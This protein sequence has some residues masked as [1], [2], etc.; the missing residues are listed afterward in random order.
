MPNLNKVMLM[1]NLTRDPELRYLPSNTPV[2]NFGVA[3][4]RRWTD[5]QSNEKREETTFVDVSAFGR[6]AEVINQY[7]KKGRPIF[8]EGRL[9]FE[10]W[11]DQS[12]NNRNRLTV[13]CEQFE[14]VGGRGEDD[15]GGGGGG[16]YGGGGGNYGNSGEGG[17]G[18]GGGG[19]QQNQAPPPPVD[20]PP[21]MPEEDIPF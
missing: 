14:F 1:G 10:Q 4:N 19:R 16:N 6:T 7:F 21:P 2:V 13:V 3:T 17:Y 18:G 15:D 9:R 20:E 5:R 11:Q 12:G 8:V